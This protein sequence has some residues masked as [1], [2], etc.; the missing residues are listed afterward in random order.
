MGER[1]SGR[2]TAFQWLA[3][4]AGLALGMAPLCAQVTPQST[5]PAELDPS[6]PLDP[7]PDLGV[8]WPDLNAP[9]P[10][11]PP[12]V[13]GVAPEAAAEATADAAEQ[14]E[15]AAAA[16]SYRWSISGIDGL[17]EA[18]GDPRQLRRRIGA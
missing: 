12:E 9:E 16:R 8:E 18:R 15:D 17:A 13:E 11:P 4:S 14:V 6:A 1:R 10:A 3:G 2:G 5:D 7:M